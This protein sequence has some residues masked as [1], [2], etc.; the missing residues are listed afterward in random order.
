MVEDQ[1]GAVGF[2]DQHHVGVDSADLAPDDD[3][4]RL[5]GDG[6]HV[7]VVAHRGLTRIKPSTRSILE[8]CRQRGSARAAPCDPR[9]PSSS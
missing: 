8:Q 7:P 4:R 1:I 2:V 3:E 5:G 9:S 6:G